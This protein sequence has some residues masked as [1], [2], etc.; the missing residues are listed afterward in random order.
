MFTLCAAIHILQIFS[1]FLK[2]T[3]RRYR[4]EQCAQSSV[5]IRKIMKD[6][7]TASALY[8]ML[9]QCHLKGPRLAVCF[10][11]G[12]KERCVIIHACMQWL[13]RFQTVSCPLDPATG[14][15]ASSLSHPTNRPGQALG[16][17]C[18]PCSCSTR[19]GRES[20]AGPGAAGMH[21]AIGG[22]SH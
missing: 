6:A 15:A 1:I 19:C 9:E 14:I 12:S 17:Q 22:V 4:S 10:A 20:V 2:Y 18:I 5:S 11:K 21:L 13:A 8:L 16:V 3:D 7:V